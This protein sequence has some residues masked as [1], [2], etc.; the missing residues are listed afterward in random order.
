M[1]E[2]RVLGGLLQRCLTG[3]LA[4]RSSQPVVLCFSRTRRSPRS[5]GHDGSLYSTSV[6]LMLVL[7]V[8]IMGGLFSN[9]PRV[10]FLEDLDLVES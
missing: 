2:R 7:H 4:D 1:N 8:Q 6:L 10:G 5:G 9:S 3:L